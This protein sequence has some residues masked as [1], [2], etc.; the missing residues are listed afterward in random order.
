MTVLR[1]DFV[2]TCMK[3]ALSQLSYFKVGFSTL[4]ISQMP[5]FSQDVTCCF[6]HVFIGLTINFSLFQLFPIFAMPQIY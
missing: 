3:I 2:L 4:I 6:F 1:V 5:F